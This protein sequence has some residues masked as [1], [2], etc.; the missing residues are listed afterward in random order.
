MDA[1]TSAADLERSLPDMAVHVATTLGV[2]PHGWSAHRWRFSRPIEGPETPVQ[3]GPFSVIG[4]AFGS[5]IGTAGAALDSAAR[6]VANL[7]C[8][9]G[10]HPAEVG[11][12]SQQTDLS[13]WGS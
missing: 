5:P 3:Q 10:W 9:T 13:T 7:H 11:A 8:A 12:S 1:D 6:A 2:D 4:D